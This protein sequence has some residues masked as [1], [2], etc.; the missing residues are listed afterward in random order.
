MVSVDN[1]IESQYRLL[2][3]RINIEFLDIY[4]SF[5]SQKIQE[6]FSTIHHLFVVN[7]SA[8]NERLPT[9]D[10]ENHFGAENSRELILAIDVL[11][12]LERVL[13]TTK[14]AF[15]IDSYYEQIIQ[16]S[17]EFLVK[18]GESAIP[19]HME[20]I[21]IYWTIPILRK[22]D[23]VE[24]GQNSTEHQYADLQKIGYGSYA[25]VYSFIDKFY[26]RK[27]VLKRA[28]ANLA[29]KEIERFK[30]EY[31]QM[32][33][34]S[35]PYIVEVYRYDGAKNEYVMEYMDFTLKEYIEKQNP[36]VDEKKRIIYQIF[37]AFKFI[38]SQNVLHRD[39][40]PAN[41]MIKTY[42]DVNVVKVCDF[43]LVKIPDSDLTSVDTI[44]KGCYNDPA[45]ITE[46]FRNYTIQHETYAL[47]RLIAFIMTGK[48]TADRI[49]DANLKAKGLSPDKN[50]RFQF[51]GKMERAFR[52]IYN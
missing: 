32:T 51:V 8:M 38:H 48:A 39:I 33:R 36:S 31:E 10:Y 49:T 2:G 21:E 47:T 5:S 3:D 13:K 26:N 37:H 43:G 22:K 17:T 16:K 40:S 29:P 50:K 7:Y 19:P 15:T 11:K 34:L 45:L 1:H 42:D 27:F 9:G 20:K 25:T 30:Q 41:I 6:I 14:D 12:S 52:S 24:L 18:S 4:Q 44:L 23:V 28:N 46:G 35:S